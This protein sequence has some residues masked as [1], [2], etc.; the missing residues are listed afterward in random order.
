MGTVVK[1][2][3]SRGVWGRSVGVEEDGFV[4]TIESRS[5]GVTSMVPYLDVVV[6]SMNYKQ[7]E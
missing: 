1:L 5:V 3:S 7:V 6:V 4:R 2:R